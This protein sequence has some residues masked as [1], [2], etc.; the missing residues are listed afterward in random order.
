MEPTTYVTIPGPK[1]TY[2][3]KVEA[4]AANLS[5]CIPALSNAKHTDFIVDR[6]VCCDKQRRAIDP[7]RNK[8]A[9]KSFNPFFNFVRKEKSRF[10]Y[11]LEMKATV[12][13]L[14]GEGIS[15]P[16]LTNLAVAVDSLFKDGAKDHKNSP[17]L[18]GVLLDIF[19]ISDFSIP[20]ATQFIDLFVANFRKNW[21]AEA[22]KSMEGTPLKRLE[23]LRS[24]Y[25][26]KNS[27]DVVGESIRQSGFYGG[28]F[29][30]SSLPVASAPPSAV[31]SSVG[32]L[33]SRPSSLPLMGVE[34]PAPIVL[35]QQPVDLSPIEAR[36][37]ALETGINSAQIAA[38]DKNLEIL[39]KE[40]KTSRAEIAKLNKVLE[41][42]VTPILDQLSLFTIEMQA[43]KDDMTELKKTV[44][45]N[46]KKA[47]TPES[48]VKNSDNAGDEDGVEVG[49]VVAA[50]ASKK[51]YVRISTAKDGEVHEF[52]TDDE[53]NL[54]VSSISDVYP[55]NY[56]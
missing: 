21:K 55:G 50:P 1:D 11:H 39:N 29:D 6:M 36:L 31:S 7:N 12:T 3:K 4:R 24:S 33:D 32:S 51:C 5:A 13:A 23:K 19:A 41:E 43:L 54:S 22:S 17:G 47:S 9:Y 38:V 8:E 34:S 30:R 40:A 10:K 16:A 52:P 2:W 27:L 28:F 46:A 56:S 14:T 49:P 20:N 35:S 42:T 45:E 53:G 25:D 18:K 37:S 44:A 26:V 48:P 15:Y